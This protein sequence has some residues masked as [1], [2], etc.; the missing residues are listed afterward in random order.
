[1]PDLDER[2]TVNPEICHGKPTV[3]GLR[4]PVSMILE[5]LAGGMSREEILADL[6]GCRCSAGWRTASNRR[7]ATS[8]KCCT[9]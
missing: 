3:R 4:Y 6:N 1:M 2:I 9:R 8:R 7:A 5:L